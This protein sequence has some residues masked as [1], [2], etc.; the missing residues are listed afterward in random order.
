MHNVYSLAPDLRCSRMVR[1][2]LCHAKSQASGVAEP[3]PSSDRGSNENV[4]NDVNA[5]DLRMESIHAFVV[6]LAR[7]LHGPHPHLKNID[8]LHVHVSDGRLLAR[9]EL[10]PGEPN[11][12]AG[13]SYHCYTFRNVAVFVN[14]KKRC[15]D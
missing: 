5:R 7:R 10:V 3:R 11:L 6:R 4:R 2:H 15:C 8:P 13:P 1:S 14:T 12:T 9:S